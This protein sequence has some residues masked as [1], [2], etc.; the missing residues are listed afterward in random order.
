MQIKDQVLA[1]CPEAAKIATG[2]RAGKPT[3]GPAK[4]QGKLDECQ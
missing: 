4:Q 2:H 1:S 3:L